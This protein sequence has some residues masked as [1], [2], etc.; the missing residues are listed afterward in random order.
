[1][2]ADLVCYNDTWNVLHL[3]HVQLSFLFTNLYRT[4]SLLLYVSSLLI[5]YEAEP[6]K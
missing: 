5:N 6:K 4:V 1:M 3:K 2:I